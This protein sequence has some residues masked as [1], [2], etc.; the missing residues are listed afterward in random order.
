[1]SPAWPRE[2][3]TG[4]DSRD[5]HNKLCGSS[6]K[7]IRGVSTLNRKSTASLLPSSKTAD[8][9]AI[10][11]SFCGGSQY[12]RETR[13]V[14][15]SVPI[16]CNRVSKAWDLCW[17]NINSRLITTPSI[18]AAQT[19]SRQPFDAMCRSTSPRKTWYYALARK[20]LS[21]TNPF[22]PRYVTSRLFSLRVQIQAFVT[23][24]KISS[25][26]DVGFQMLDSRVD[27]HR[28]RNGRR[29]A[30]AQHPINRIK[31]TTTNPNLCLLYIW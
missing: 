10:E 6:G 31:P 26:Y 25:V 20:T 4:A 2:R 15:R 3:Q 18:A 17:I 27:L 19:R 13:P 30:V 5:Q 16:G 14:L 28:G 23:Q 1:V 29:V 11:G 12:R 21:A 24:N 22:K 7:V 8:Q 9:P